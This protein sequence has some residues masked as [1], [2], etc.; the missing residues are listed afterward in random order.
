MRHTRVSKHL[1]T[2]NNIFK[3]T[4]LTYFNFNEGR[5]KVPWF[6]IFFLLLHRRFNN[7]GEI[8]IKGEGA[9]V[10]LK[11]ILGGS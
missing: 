1:S 7:A 2:T 6:Y 4:T 3:A 11:K 8:L 5:R 9:G 10:L